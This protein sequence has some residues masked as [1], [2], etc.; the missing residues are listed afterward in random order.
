MFR[1]LLICLML[2]TTSVFASDQDLP[3]VVVSA[4]FHN[5]EELDTITSITVLSETEKLARGATHLEALLN[6]VP[7]LNYAMGTSRARFFQIRGIGERSQ[8]AEPLNSSVGLMIDG[9]DF[10]GLGTIATLTDLQQIEILRGPQGTRFGANG[11]AG[12]IAITTKDP[13]PDSSLEITTGIASHNARQASITLNQPLTSKT[14]A[15]LNFSRQ[16]ADGHYQN[17]F[18]DRSDTND[19]DEHHLNLKLVSEGD[20]FVTKLTAIVADVDNGFDAF[21][22]DNTRN[23]LSDEPGFDRQKTKALAVSLQRNLTAASL[24]FLASISDSKLGY[25]YDEDWSYVGIHPFG[26][27]STDEYFR[28]QSHRSAELRLVSSP[29]L[30]RDEA[31]T[32]WALGLYRTE[33]RSDLLRRYTFAAP[34]NSDYS[35]KATALFAET[36]LSL[37]HRVKLNAGLRIERRRREFDDSLLVAFDPSETLWGGRLGLQYGLNSGGQLYLS[38]SKGFKAGGFNTDGT[39]DEALREFDSETLIETELGF[40]AQTQRSRIRFALFHADRRDQQVKSSLV[41][42][43]SDGSTEFIDFLGNAAEGV[44]QGLEVEVETQ[45]FE[46]WQLRFAGGYLDATFDQ[47]INE[48]GDDLGGREQAQAPKVTASAALSFDQ[49]NRFAS[50]G[51][52]HKASYYF[53][54]RH[55]TRSKAFTTVNLALGMEWP[56]WRLS[57]WGRNLTDETIYTRGFGSFGND[58]RKDYVTEPYFQ[59]GEPRTIGLTVSYLGQRGQ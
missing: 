16:I 37:A 55:D 32:T 20:S 10:S 48:F 36:S 14:S 24:E 45:L 42:A 56:N 50:L 21:T 27:Q 2:C 19:I 41:L 38:L 40:K 30:E 31:A 34:Y 11:L 59:F 15:R 33:L 8:Y 3:E 57:V 58:P 29:S 53:S 9:I 4:D 54:D 17:A 44:N 7:N 13:Q 46:S 39:L 35:N 26:Y 25:G 12:L 1:T 51:I 28:D 43:R 18:L 22:L 47:F 52:D 23:T 49:G 5:S 6:L